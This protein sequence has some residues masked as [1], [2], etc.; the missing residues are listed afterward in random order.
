M[1]LNYLKLSIRLLLRNPFFALV[2]IIGLSIGF[3]AFFALWQYSTAELKTDQHHKDFERIVRIGFHQRWNEPGNVMNL[4]FGPSRASLPPQFKNDFPEVESYV[5]IS[6][7]GGFFQEDLHEGHGVR[8]VIAYRGRNGEERIFKEMKAAYADRNIFEFFT[9]PLIHG[10]PETVLDGEL[11]RQQWDCTASSSGC[12]SRRASLPAA[13]R[14]RAEAGHSAGAGAGR[15][16]HDR[17][18]RPGRLCQPRDR[19]PRVHHA[20]DDPP[21]VVDLARHRLRVRRVRRDQGARP[22]SATST[23]RCTSRRPRSLRTS[24]GRG[25][26]RP[27]AR[28][29]MRRHWPKPAGCA[30]NGGK[31]GGRS[32][33]NRTSSGPPRCTPQ[34]LAYEREH[35]ADDADQRPEAPASTADHVGAP[36]GFTGI[37][38]TTFYPTCRATTMVP[39]LRRHVPHGR[40]ERPVLLLAD[41]RDGRRWVRQVGRAAEVRVHGQGQRADHAREAVRR[42]EALVRD[43]G[44]IADLLGPR[45]GCFLFQL[46]PSFHYSPAALKRVARAA[47]PGRPNVVEFRHRSWWN[48]TRLPSV[49]RRG[50]RLLLVQ[51]PAAAGRAGEDGRRRLRPV[52]R[53]EAVVPP[54]LHEGGAGGVGRRIRDERR[55]AGVGVL[56][57]RPG[58]LRD[59]ERAGV[60]AAVEG[61]RR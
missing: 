59:Q 48:E 53:D 50:T 2:N 39:T 14:H 18:V 5:R 41:R 4:T 11:R 47:R 55:E 27:G 3:T 6:E 46:P 30:G 54:R 29:K 51:R 25:C 34:R 23:R 56:Q 43:F 22:P 38:G 20:A 12:S 33:A 8:M 44:H 37:G 61:C 28:A 21:D 40:A 36:G 57:Q 7:Q 60:A 19:D 58:R 49:P 13:R 15:V 17:P 1:L 26:E 52:P 24:R 45:F 10:D 42:H 9:I 32:S 31:P 35:P 16:L